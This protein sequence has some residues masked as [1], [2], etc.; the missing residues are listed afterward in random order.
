M[1]SNSNAANAER[2]SAIALLRDA[3]YNEA[4]EPLQKLLNPAEPT[5]IQSVAASAISVVGGRR[6]EIGELLLDGWGG[7]GGELRNQ[8]I[9]LLLARTERLGALFD[10]SGGQGRFNLTRLGRRGESCFS[11]TRS[12]GSAARAEEALRRSRFPRRCARALPGRGMDL[13]GDPVKGKIVYETVCIA[14][15]KFREKGIID[16]ALRTLRWSRAGK[17]NAF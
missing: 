17:P 1:A 3:P 2:V 9:Q 7:Y 12:P 6:P 15:H 5:E 4:G 13:T 11:H 8:V 10:A 14:C 16:L